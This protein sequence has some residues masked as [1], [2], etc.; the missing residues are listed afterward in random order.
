MSDSVTLWTAAYQAHVHG[1]FQARV[2]EWGAIAFSMYHVTFHCVL[3]SGTFILFHCY[4]LSS[5]LLPGC[6]LSRFSRVRLF[7]TPWTVAHQAP[8]SMLPY[9]PGDL[10]DPG[11]EPKSPVL[12]A[13]SSPTGGICICI[14][15]CVCI[16]EDNG[17]PLQYS[18]LENP[19]DRGAW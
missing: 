16:G 10:P 3:C 12:Q 15:I 18:C 4:L 2:L 5:M 9:P 1:I 19:M 11:I 6:M 8:L 13:D 14:Y 17:N 7:V